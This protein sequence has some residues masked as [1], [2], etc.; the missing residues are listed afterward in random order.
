MRR[1]L[2]AVLA[3]AMIAG[4]A[5]QVMAA[6]VQGTELTFPITVSF[7]A[8][9]ILL[10]NDGTSLASWGIVG[11]S[12]NIFSNQTG[13]QIRHSVEQRGYSTIDF[14]AR[15][16][17][18]TVGTAW[19]LGATLGSAASNQAVVAG[20]FTEALETGRTLV[21]ADFANN[22]VLGATDIVAT[23]NVLARDGAGDPEAIKGYHVPDVPGG[24]AMRSLRYLLQTPTADTT[25]IQ[26][27]ITITIG[28]NAI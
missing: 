11:A 26:Q 9:S 12:Q 3:V 4:M 27:T 5:T 10:W 2:L 17:V 1:T 28:A 19:T 15:A 6:P 25:G 14:K 8:D 20:I 22:D 18:T 13:G 16:A 24:Y 7:N 23:T 21:L